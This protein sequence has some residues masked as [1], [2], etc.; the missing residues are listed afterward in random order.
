MNAVPIASCAALALG[1]A[2]G[3]CGPPGDD[4]QTGSISAEQAQSARA[5]LSPEVA[6]RLDSGNAAYEEGR[7]ED[8]AELYRRVVETNPDVAAGWFGVY[9]AERALGNED[10]ARAALERAGAVSEKGGD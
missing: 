2:L 4:Q 6:S 1:V 7:Y 5:R 3:G 9:M 10:S 8:A